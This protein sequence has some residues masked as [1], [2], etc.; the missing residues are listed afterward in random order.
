M[1]SDDEEVT[2]NLRRARDVLVEVAQSPEVRA[3]YDDVV[4]AVD[5][6]TLGRVVELAWRHQFATDRYGF[7]KDVREIADAI[8]IVLRQKAGIR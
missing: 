3:T 1:P 8:V 2:D 5:R 6:K 4:A 7:K